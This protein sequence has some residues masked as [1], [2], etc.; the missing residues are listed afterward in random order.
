M[1][2]FLFF[3]SVRHEGLSHRLSLVLPQTRAM[4]V[5][6]AQVPKEL[7]GGGTIGCWCNCQCL[8]EEKKNGRVG[9]AT[10]LLDEGVK[11]RGK[12]RRG[13]E[14]EGRTSAMRAPPKIDRGRVW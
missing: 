7:D 11:R 6:E 13:R 8:R 9:G 3:F 12:K 4:Q 5:R 14:I 2:S 10:M 1:T